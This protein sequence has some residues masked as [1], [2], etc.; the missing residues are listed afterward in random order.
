MLFSDCADG[1]PFVQ[2]RFVPSGALTHQHNPEAIRT[3]GYL[4]NLVRLTVRFPES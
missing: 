4:W 1:G 3:G 2:S